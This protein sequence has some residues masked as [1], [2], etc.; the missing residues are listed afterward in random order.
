MFV[1]SDMEMILSFLLVSLVF[2]LIIAATGNTYTPPQPLSPSSRSPSSDDLM[3]KLA[4]G[5]C[6]GFK[7]EV[8]EILSDIG[9]ID[10]S[11]MVSHLILTKRSLHYIF[12]L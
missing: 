10:P 5:N 12:P 11:K 6:N 1:S 3:R 9:L 7:I 4:V 8:P 2:P